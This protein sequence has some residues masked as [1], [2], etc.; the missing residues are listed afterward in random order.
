VHPV[1]EQGSLTGFFSVLS[2]LM[3]LMHKNKSQEDEIG[4]ELERVCSQV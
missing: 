3:E 2:D 1:H 4:S